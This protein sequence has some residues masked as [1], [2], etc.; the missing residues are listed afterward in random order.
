VTEK[1]DEG[2]KLA[3]TTNLKVDNP[4]NMV[5]QW[6]LVQAIFLSLGQL[7]LVKWVLTRAIFLSLSLCLVV[8]WFMTRAIFLSF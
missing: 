5:V 2:Q 1:D 4:R 8:K 6:F 7:L 3:G